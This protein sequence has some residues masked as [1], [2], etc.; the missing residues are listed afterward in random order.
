MPDALFMFIFDSTL[1]SGRF[2]KWQE[3]LVPIFLAVGQVSRVQT[4]RLE[5]AA[6]ELS[7]MSLLFSHFISRNKFIPV[8]SG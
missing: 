2:N 3:R 7:R 4:S 6:A 8:K 5:P 1:K